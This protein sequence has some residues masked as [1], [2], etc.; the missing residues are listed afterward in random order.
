MSGAVPFSGVKPI[1][2]QDLSAVIGGSNVTEDNWL[3]NFVIDEYLKLVSVSC[4]HSKVHAIGWELF[5]NG[6]AKRVCK[7]LQR[8]GKVAE[9]D[10]IL[11]PCNAS[12]HWFLLCVL[13]KVQQILILDSAA[14]DYVKPTTE[15]AVVKMLEIFEQTGE[16]TNLHEW[17][18][19][20]N[21]KS[22]IPQQQNTYD[23]GIFI[24]LYARSL[25]RSDP[26]VV[27]NDIPLFRRSMV[28]DLNK[29]KLSPHPATNVELEKYYAVDYL[30]KFYIGRALSI[31]GE[32]V[33]FKFLHSAGAM[34]FNWPGRDDVEAKHT[35]CVFYG[36]VKLE[37]GSPFKL[38]RHQEIALLHNFLKIKK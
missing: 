9:Q 17:A 14:G 35:S 27:A 10:L 11:V 33:S 25:A 36:P 12:D 32:Y 7:E 18:C 38:A 34:T 31:D 26:F 22:E 4:N 15:I 29:Q 8:S 28:V 19:Y 6:T 20:T 23:C 1:D 30:K 13:P 24:C 37:G 5:E 2:I 16:F 3:S 21:T